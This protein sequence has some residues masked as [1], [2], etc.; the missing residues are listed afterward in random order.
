MSR[1]TKAW[2]LILSPPTNLSLNGRFN[3]LLLF[4]RKWVGGNQSRQNKGVRSSGY[5]RR[6][7]LLHSWLI[8]CVSF[9]V[10]S[11][12]YCCW[13]TCE[14]G[15]REGPLMFKAA[16]TDLCFVLLRVGKLVCLTF[17][18]IGSCNLTLL[19]H[20]YHFGLTNTGW[21]Q[22]ARKSAGRRRPP[23]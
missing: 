19:A 5:G 6:P 16:S 21:V 13:D 12:C 1:E 22:K 18:I 9:C 3:F 14:R 11:V 7:Q 10:E 17:P 4:E 23:L 2:L 15:R 8:R 20:P